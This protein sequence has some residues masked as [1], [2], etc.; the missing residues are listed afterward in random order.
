M[1]RIT[2]ILQPSEGELVRLIARKHVATM[3]PRLLLAGALIVLP[4]F[5]LFR[6][7]QSGTIGVV[8]FV[9][10]VALGLFVALRAFLLWDADV[11]VLTSHRVVDVDQRGLLSRSV[12]E[13]PLIHIHDVR[14]LRQGWNETL[15]RMGTLRIRATGV[16]TQLVIPKLPRPERIVA[17]LEQERAKRGSR[18]GIVDRVVDLLDQADPKTLD[19]IDQVM[20]EKRHG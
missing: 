10:S 13:I 14:W 9:C 7:G 1:F 11:F 2:D 12:A 3:F 17:A 15:W 5:F 20:R 4:F 8:A 18:G 6:L 19:A 16:T